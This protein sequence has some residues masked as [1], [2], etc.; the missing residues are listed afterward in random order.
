MIHSV[1]GVIDTRPGPC[2]PVKT[3]PGVG[4]K[5]ELVEQLFVFTPPE[6]MRPVLGDWA[7]LDAEPADAAEEIAAFANRE[8]LDV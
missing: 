6:R 8:R 2:V 1:F 5:S 3:S 4:Y 7:T